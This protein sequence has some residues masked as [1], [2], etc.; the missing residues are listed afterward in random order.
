MR[1]SFHERNGLWIVGQAV[2]DNLA[3][4]L[5]FTVVSR[6]AAKNTKRHQRREAIL[7]FLRLFVLFVAKWRGLSGTA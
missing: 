5:W 4:M 2:P 6:M 1:A 3:D 7:T